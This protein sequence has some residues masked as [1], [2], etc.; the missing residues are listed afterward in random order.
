MKTQ[1]HV[2]R[3]GP[4]WSRLPAAL[5]AVMVF[6][7]EMFWV[8]YASCGT[9]CVGLMKTS[10]QCS[11]VVEWLS[12]AEITVE[13]GDHMFGGGRLNRIFYRR[14]MWKLWVWIF[15]TDQNEKLIYKFYFNLCIS[16][17]SSQSLWAE[18][19]FNDL[20]QIC[21]SDAVVLICE[22]VFIYP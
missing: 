11:K 19:T 6:Y 1:I 21:S 2:S 17:V 9:S 13:K 8:L 15:L 20:V 7:F 4:G 3:T 16:A 12:W 14:T 10:W 22:C 18:T 5:P